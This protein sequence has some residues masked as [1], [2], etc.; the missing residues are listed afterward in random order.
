MEVKRK[1]ETWTS[2]NVEVYLVL[3]I[4]KLTFSSSNLQN[5]NPNWV[6]ESINTSQGR[7]SCFKNNEISVNKFVYNRQGLFFLLVCKY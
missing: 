1:V 4:T 7:E 3:L 6:Y 2:V 5:S